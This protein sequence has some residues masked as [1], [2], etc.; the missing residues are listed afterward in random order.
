[1]TLSH[2]NFACG[3]PATHLGA[4]DVCG[5]VEGNDTL[6]EPTIDALVLACMHEPILFDS[7]IEVIG[8][9]R[10]LDRQLRRTQAQLTRQE[11]R[12]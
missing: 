12:S 3:G 6:D 7:T 4:C 2:D 1:V 11:I 9:L 8:R 10:K 5:W